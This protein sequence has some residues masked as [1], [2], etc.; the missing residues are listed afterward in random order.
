MRKEQQQNQQMCV[1]QVRSTAAATIQNERNLKKTLSE[2][3]FYRVL[4]HC[5]CLS[6][7]EI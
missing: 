1:K 4:I 6:N 2:C 7:I 3:I 5:R